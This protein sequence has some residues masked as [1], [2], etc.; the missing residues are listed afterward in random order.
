M[1]KGIKI[2]LR[3]FEFCAKVTAFFAEKFSNFDAGYLILEAGKI[4]ETLNL[5]PSTTHLGHKL[6]TSI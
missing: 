3:K 5:D 2:F 6:R 1:G 4:E